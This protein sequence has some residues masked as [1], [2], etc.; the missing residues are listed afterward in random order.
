MGQVKIE[1][2]SDSEDDEK[3]EKKVE[4]KKKVAKKKAATPKVKDVRNF[5]YHTRLSDTFSKY[6]TTILGTVVDD[7]DAEPVVNGEK[8]LKPHQLLVKRYLNAQTMYRGLLLYHGL[9]S[10]KTCTAIAVA[11]GFF[12]TK[13]DILVFTPASLRDNFQQEVMLPFCGGENAAALL[14]KIQFF[15]YNGAGSQTFKDFITKLASGNNPFDNAVVIVDE[16]HRLISM[17][18]NKHKTKDD[19]NDK[20]K[21][22]FATLFYQKLCSARQAKIVFLTGT[23]LVQHPLE[24]AFLFNMLRGD[25]IKYT[26]KLKDLKHENKLNFVATIKTKLKAVNGVVFLSL[27]GSTLQVM[28]DPGYTGTL[29]TFITNVKSKLADDLAGGEPSKSVHQCLPDEPDTLSRKVTQQGEFSNLFLNMDAAKSEAETNMKNPLLFKRRIMGLTSFYEAK[30]DDEFMPKVSEIQLIKLPFSEHQFATYQE[31]R[32]VETTQNKKSKYDDAAML[33]GDMKSSYRLLSRSA[34]NFVF[35]KTIARPQLQGKH[36]LDEMTGGGPSDDEDD[37]N[38]NSDETQP[39]DYSEVEEEDSDD[40]SSASASEAEASEA[41]E[42]EAEASAI[43]ADEA[44]AE[45]DRADASASASDADDASASAKYE[46]IVLKPQAKSLETTL[47]E[48]TKYFAADKEKNYLKDLCPKFEAIIA[49]IKLKAASLHLVYS[50]FLTLEGIGI[51][52]MVLE[53]HGFLEFKLKNN[54][55][56]DATFLETWSKNKGARTFVKYTGAQDADIKKQLL[57]IYNANWDNVHPN[58]K[59]QLQQINPKFATPGTRNDSGKI[60]QVILITAAGREGIS[61]KSTRFVHIME[62]YWHAVATEQ[63]IGRA[64]RLNSHVTLDADKRTVTVFLYMMTFSDPQKEKIKQ[65]DPDGKSTDEYMYA[66]GQKKQQLVGS[67]LKAIKESAIDCA[68]WQEKDKDKCATVTSSTMDCKDE[69]RDPV[70][71]TTPEPEKTPEEEPKEEPEATPKQKKA[72]RAAK[73]KKAREVENTSLETEMSI[74]S[75]SN[76]PSKKRKI[77]ISSSPSPMGGRRKS[78]KK[79]QRKKNKNKNKNKNKGKITRK[80]KLR[81]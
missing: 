8:T 4:A 32:Q 40:E 43:E 76:L 48:L 75:A 58:I 55:E 6:V 2:S 1:T 57:Y 80:K 35:P 22:E 47:Q 72:K 33:M 41:D 13:R 71:S 29:Q 31:V 19:G 63:I 56:I 20:N 27:F 44:E 42:A 24:A 62:P 81:K 49:K 51:F 77:Q 66:L 59:T 30:A 21:N 38:E 65:I 5:S 74:G 54:H 23:P 28:V 25:F 61:L 64:S 67:F 11:E 39:G 79:T 52:G 46:P 17:I 53:D 9:G 37:A 15:N 34:C 16:V 78:Q 70:A 50:Q 60:I 69:P 36:L 14:Q 68:I 7:A 45:A 18:F 12:D 3:P 73:P 26:F 10:G